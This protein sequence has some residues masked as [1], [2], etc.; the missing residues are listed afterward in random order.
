MVKINRIK[1]I[2][3]EKDMSKK[4]A[5][6]Y[7]GVS[8]TTFGR[9]LKQESQPDVEH[10]ILL[11]RLFEFDSLDLLFWPDIIKTAEIEK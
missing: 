10:S 6:E 5:Y 2:L 11:C 4:E 8:R 7:V 3:A 1:V 9:W